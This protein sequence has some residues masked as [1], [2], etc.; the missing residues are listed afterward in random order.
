MWTPE[1]VK[2]TLDN[3]GAKL[4]GVNQ[5]IAHLHNILEPDENI[6]FA[7]AGN[8][9]KIH[10]REVT[11]TGMAILT[12]KRIIFYRRSFI[13]TETKETVRIGNISS[14][15]NRKGILNSSLCIYAANNESEVKL[16][17]KEHAEIMASKINSLVNQQHSSPASNTQAAPVDSLAQLEKLFELKSKGAITE[18]EY[19]QHKQK[20]LVN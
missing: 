1:K 8:L 20:L 3:I 16:F 4:V 13:G 5:E 10:G 7:V 6:E 14:V 17:G 12:Q 18:E 19:Q 9:A 2:A 11:G 15:S